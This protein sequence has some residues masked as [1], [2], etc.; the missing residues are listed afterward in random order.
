[1]ENTKIIDCK[2]NEKI[3]KVQVKKTVPYSKRVGA[4]NVIAEAIVLEDGNYYPWLFNIHHTIFVLSTYTDFV[5][6]ENWKD[7][8]IMQFAA[9]DSYK[10]ILSIID[11]NEL[12]EVV[13]WAKELID[14]RKKCYENNM[15]SRLVIGAKEIFKIFQ[16]ELMK[17]PE[18]I[19]LLGSMINKKILQ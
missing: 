6:P 5:F 10:N 18:A 11:G 1:M 9:S 13:E 12:D 3:I 7:D 19:E 17:D 15:L 14:Y 16:E 8:D 2:V 4:A